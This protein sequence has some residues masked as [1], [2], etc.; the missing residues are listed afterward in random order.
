[1]K[2]IIDKMKLHYEFEYLIEDIENDSS[3]YEKFKE[4]IPVLLI[5]GKLFAKYSVNEF[6]LESKLLKLN[7][8]KLS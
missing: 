3:L 8:K 1:M 6:K 2:A 4:T 7:A 5:N